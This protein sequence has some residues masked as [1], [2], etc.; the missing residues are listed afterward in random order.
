MKLIND[1]TE[2]E[3]ESTFVEA[4]FPGLALEL[5]K[6]P[7]DPFK[8]SPSNRRSDETEVYRQLIVERI[9]NGDIQTAFKLYCIGQQ[10]PIFQKIINREQPISDAQTIRDI[11][12]EILKNGSYEEDKSKFLSICDK[13]YTVLKS[14]GIMSF[15]QKELIKKWITGRGCINVGDSVVSMVIRKCVMPQRDNEVRT[16][17][18]KRQDEDEQ[19]MKE[20]MKDHERRIRE[21]EEKKKEEMRRLINVLTEYESKSKSVEAG[22]ESEEVSCDP[23]TLLPSNGSS[24]EVEVYRQLILERI[25]D[26]EIT[27]AFKLY[28]IGHYI[29]FCREI[30]NGNRP[31]S[32]EQ[33]IR[34]IFDEMLKNGSYEAEKSKFLSICHKWFTV[35]NSLGMMSYIQRELILIWITGR[36]CINIED[37]VVSMVIR[38]CVM[39]QKDNEVR[40]EKLKDEDEQR[41]KEN[42]KNHERRIRERDEKE[43][44]EMSRLTNVLTEYESKSKSVEAGLESEAMS[45]DPFTSLPSN[46]SSDEAEVYRQLIVE[47]INDDDITTAFKLYCI[48]HYI[49]FCKEIINGNRLISNDQTIGDMFDEMSKK[50]SYEEEESK[51]LSICDKWYTEKMMNYLQKELLKKWIMGGEYTNMKDSIVSMVIKKCVM[52]QKDNEVR[53]EELKRQEK[54]EYKQRRNESLKD[55]DWRISERDE[56]KKEEM[57]RLRNDLTEYESKSKSVEAGLESEAMSRDPFASL[58]SNGRSD[59]AEVYRQSVEAGLESEAVSCDPLKLLPSNERSDEAKVYRQLIVEKITDDDITTAFKLYCIGH[60]IQFCRGIINGNRPISNDQTIR[61]MFDGMPKKESYE[62][63][64]S[65]F[66]SI[67]DKWHELLEREYILGTIRHAKR[68]NFWEKELLKNWITDRGY[69]DIEDSVVSMVIRIC[70]MPHKDNEVREERI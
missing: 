11:F 60:Y 66:L 23:F 19:W 28:C 5:M 36:K 21:R 63:E 16:E 20:I 51:F 50:E 30:I 33:T 40:T 35:L 54:D 56:K 43:K 17:E 42:M 46:E 62:E 6:V 47:S 26:C 67:L 48:G 70:V 4:S 32:N 65:K 3:Y 61:D 9:M 24:D 69:S 59:E 53:T 2:Y 41:R 38:K 64:K 49:P 55:H 45:R 37:S 1:L 57:R 58:P 15:K 27:T 44:E 25:N 52:R 18:F 10:M 68:M 8:L 7:C 14:T 31:I 22:L 39:P 29:P 12:D 34:D 13:W